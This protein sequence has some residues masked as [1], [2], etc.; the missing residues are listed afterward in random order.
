MRLGWVE[1]TYP[2]M[3]LLMMMFAIVEQGQQIP[4][5]NP[6]FPATSG[7]SDWKREKEYEKEH[8]KNLARVRQSVT[9]SCCCKVRTPSPRRLGL[10]RTCLPS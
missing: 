10:F 7:E 1:P 9:G 3:W 2:Q 4:E 6:Q 8:G 5:L